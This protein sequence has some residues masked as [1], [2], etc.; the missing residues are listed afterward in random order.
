ME[1]NHE[2]SDELK[3]E[4]ANAEA[5]E[6]LSEEELKS[7]TGGSSDNLDDDGKVQDNNCRLVLTGI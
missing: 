6:Q 3:K 5:E 4:N 2:L 1:M 7:V